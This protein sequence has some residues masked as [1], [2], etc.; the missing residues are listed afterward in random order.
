MLMSRSHLLKSKTKAVLI[1][2]LLATL[3]WDALTPVAANCLDDFVNNPANALGVDLTCCD[4]T[5]NKTIPDNVDV[6]MPNLESIELQS[7]S[8]VE[9]CHRVWD[10][11][12]S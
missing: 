1:V 4:A 11:L 6:M 12:H 2:G 7:C 10:D 3:G 5:V 9:A 8:L